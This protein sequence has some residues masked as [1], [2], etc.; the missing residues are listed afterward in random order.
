MVINLRGT[1][2][3]GKST[4]ARNLMSRYN[5]REAAFQ[6]GRKRPIGYECRRADGAPLW[7]V[8][9]YETACGGG[10]TITSLDE[11]YR[12]VRTAADAGKDVLYEGLI[13]Q[14]D[15]ARC[16]DLHH[17]YPVLVLI[18][19]VPLETCLA[20]VQARR[21]A[22]GDA[23]PLNPANTLSK[24]KSIPGQLRRLREGGVDVRLVGREEAEQICVEELR[25]PTERTNEEP[26]DI[27]QLR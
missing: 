4:L 13:I 25:L 9:H 2:G 26:S 5:E 24:A 18:L 21:D 23:R 11:V 19:D 22:R 17:H 27:F 20:S 16:V 8:G 7:V 12:L 3:S 1:S 14:S 15:I 6:A 10:D